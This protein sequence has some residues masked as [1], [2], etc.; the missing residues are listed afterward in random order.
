MSRVPHFNSV[1]NYLSSERLTP[2][3]QDLITTSSLPLKA[4][5]S[6]FAV[7]ASG[8]STS[9][10]DQWFD[11]KYG[12]PQKRRSR[13]WLKCHL[14]VG[15]RTNVV[16]SVEMSPWNAGDS[17]YFAPLVQR[18]AQNFSLREVSADKA[19]LSRKNVG[20]VEQLGATPYVPFKASSVPMLQ[21]LF[22]DMETAWSRMY[23][24]FSLNREAFMASYHKRSNVESAFSM[25][26]GK[27]GDSVLSKSPAG[28]ANEVL[29]KVLAHNVV[30]AAR[31]MHE[32]GLA[33]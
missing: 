14:M 8:F 21:A 31:Y 16:T 13:A 1:C 17:P 27:F 12:E 30:V 25:I 32:L 11:F 33:A 23:H 20:L 7:D 15:V 19:Y 6:D 5:E 28:Q 10:F 9:R 24:A 26:K 2:V 4:V 18:T 29:C 22:P 3:L